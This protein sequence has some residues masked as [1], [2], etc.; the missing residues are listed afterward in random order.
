MIVSNVGPKVE[1]NTLKQGSSGLV[2]HLSDSD[3]IVTVG[4]QLIIRP[5]ESIAGTTGLE[6]TTSAVTADKEA[7]NLQKTSVT[8]G[9]SWRSKERSGTVN[10]VCGLIVCAVSL[11]KSSSAAAIPQ[12]NSGKTR[13]QALRRT[14]E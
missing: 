12:A 14:E 9:S 8:D 6:P 3:L 7:R 11:S 5:L 13:I 1:E 4:R 10:R 2:G